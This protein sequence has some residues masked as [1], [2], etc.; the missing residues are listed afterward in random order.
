MGGPFFV[1]VLGS[2]S[3]TDLLLMRCTD[4]LAFSVALLLFGCRHAEEKPRTA[5]GTKPLQLPSM[6]L[7]G[8]GQR[9]LCRRG[10][11]V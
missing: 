8:Q 1:L 5:P 11:A 2:Y 4:F 9:D 3:S 10:I 7:S 6:D